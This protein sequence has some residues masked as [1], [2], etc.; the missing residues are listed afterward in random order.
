MDSNVDS[1]SAPVDGDR[2]SLGVRVA[3]SPVGKPVV[4]ALIFVTDSFWLS[5]TG[6]G[7]LLVLIAAAT[8]GGV[9]AGI[10]GVF[11][12]SSIAVGVFGY[13]TYLAYVTRQD[14]RS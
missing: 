6:V 11:G 2:K 13:L 8:G 3:E 14:T 10:T 12:L 9:M 5:L 1:S 4:G 7:L